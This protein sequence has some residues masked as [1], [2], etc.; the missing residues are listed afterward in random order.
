MKRIFI[1]RLFYRSPKRKGVKLNTKVILNQRFL[2]KLTFD[3]SVLHVN[4]AVKLQP[5][6]RELENTSIGCQLFYQRYRWME[7]IFVFTSRSRL[8]CVWPPQYIH[9]SFEYYTSF[10]MWTE[11]CAK[12]MTFHFT[13]NDLLCACVQHTFTHSMHIAQSHIGN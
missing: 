3:W 4:S 2:R 12:K 5:C 10:W 11:P 1:I 6:V 13:E 9:G 8:L 7:I